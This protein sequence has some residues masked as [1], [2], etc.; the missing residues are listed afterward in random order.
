MAKEFGAIYTP[1]G[2]A[3]ILANW[4]I[5]SK[6]DFVL[7][8]GIGLGVFVYQSYARLMRL[9]AT[10]IKATK[11]IYGSEIDK[12]VFSQFTSEAAER[13]L[14]FKNLHNIDLFNA[15]FPSLDAIIGNPPY[16]RRRGMNQDNLNIIRTQTLGKI[17]ISR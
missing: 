15:S 6:D 11:Q 7:D 8:M 12:T 10:K 2:H 3:R 1:K 4:A 9:G 13:G 5:Q 16:V 17:K 14:T